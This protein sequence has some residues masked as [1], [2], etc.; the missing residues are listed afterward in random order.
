MFIVYGIVCHIVEIPRFLKSLLELIIC[1]V[2]GLVAIFYFSR[3]IGCH[4]SSQLTN[5]NIFQRGGEKPPTS[6]MFIVLFES[7]V[8]D[9]LSPVSVG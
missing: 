3:N 6:N 4:S 7:S 9:F 8:C 5:S 1:L 2:G